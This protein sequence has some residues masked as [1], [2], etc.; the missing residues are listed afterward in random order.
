MNFASFLFKDIFRKKISL[1][2]TLAGVAVGIASCVI[3]L[4]LTDSIKS[5]FV[6]VHEKRGIDIVVFEKDELSFA[7]SR[8]DAAVEE[9]IRKMPGV[10]HATAMFLD[11]QRYKNAFLPLYGWEADS[12]LFVELTLT[13]GR[14]PGPGAGEEAGGF[15]AEKSKQIVMGEKFA[16]MVAI[17]TIAAVALGL[18]NTM[19]TSVFNKRKLI[20]MLMAVGW[21]KADVMKAL[22]AESLFVAGAGGLAGSALGF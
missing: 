13:E 12:P 11:F 9:G 1:F 20:G 16:V 17:V 4:G 7:S 2:L 5:S 6:N 10:K 8:V 22:F 18:A 14:F 3:V 15:V 19:M 21:R